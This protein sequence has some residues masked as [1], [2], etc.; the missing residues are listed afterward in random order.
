MHLPDR[1]QARLAHGKPP[2]S[3]RN[4]LSRS[5]SQSQ[6][7]PSQ[8]ACRRRSRGTQS[9]ASQA[10]A[11]CLNR[12]GAHL[13]ASHRYR[14]ATWPQ[15]ESSARRQQ[16]ARLRPV[17]QPLRSRTRAPSARF[18]TAGHALDHLRLTWVQAFRHRLHTAPQ[19]PSVRTA[20]GTK[21]TRGRLPMSRYLLRSE[22]VLASH[23]CGTVR[24][25][26]DRSKRFSRAAGS[27]RLRCSL[28]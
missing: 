27:H 23:L 9:L 16:G 14:S 10:P 19:S 5:R 22:R 17:P 8:Q 12:N 7:P 6:F 4:T 3:R 18:L 26:D 15:D 20:C 13:P 1:N 24:H 25:G 11:P 28:P 21:S 2:Q